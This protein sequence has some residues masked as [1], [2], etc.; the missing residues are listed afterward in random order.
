MS[1]LA[2][3]EELRAVFEAG[4]WTASTKPDVIYAADEMQFKSGSFVNHAK[5]FIYPPIEPW[6]GINYIPENGVLSAEITLHFVISRDDGDDDKL[7][8]VR[9]DM[10]S[11]LRDGKCESYDSNYLERF[12][13]IISMNSGGV[14]QVMAQ[15]EIIVRDDVV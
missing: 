12:V 15:G 11:I 6:G 1:N 2:V 8:T 5:L 7:I 4:S 13:P 14:R 3:G 9:N 10:I